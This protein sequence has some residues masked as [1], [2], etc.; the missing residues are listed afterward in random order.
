[1]SGSLKRAM[2]KRAG[3]VARGGGHSPI[4][5]RPR[6]K[7]S[8]NLEGAAGPL[9]DPLARLFPQPRPS[10]GSRGAPG[11]S[12]PAPCGKRELFPRGALQVSGRSR[13]LSTAGCP[14]GAG[15]PWEPRGRPFVLGWFVCL[16]CGLPFMLIRPALGLIDLRGGQPRPSRQTSAL[17][18]CG[19]NKDGIGETGVR[20]RH[21][22]PPSPA[23]VHSPEEPGMLG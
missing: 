17:A 3:T 10:R 21:S 2:A 13:A 23:S 11:M 1:M 6:G 16:L 15:E 4:Q 12:G 7:P 22:P 14:G 5:S 9:G 19:E 8:G 20:G 18:D